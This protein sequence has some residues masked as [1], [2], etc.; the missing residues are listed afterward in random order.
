MDNSHS[1]TAPSAQ[2]VQFQVNPAVEFIRFYLPRQI[3]PFAEAAR[4]LNISPAGLRKAMLEGRVRLPMRKVLGGIH[5]ITVGDLAKFLYPQY[6]SSEMP[7][8]TPPSPSSA[9]P[10]GRGRPR[11]AT[12]EGGAR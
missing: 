12:T 11:K 1:T 9:T 8:P 2:Q 10:R 6:F 3:I 7:P 4:V 5:G